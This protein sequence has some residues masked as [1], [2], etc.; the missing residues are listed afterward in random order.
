MLL[1]ASHRRRS[2]GYV[3]FPDEPSAMTARNFYSGWKLPGQNGVGLSLEVRHV[4]EVPKNH[5]LFSLPSS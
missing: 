2:V 1:H 5:P 4:K 3:D